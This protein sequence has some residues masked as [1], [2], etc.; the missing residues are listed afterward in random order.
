MYICTSK[1]F[2]QNFL[3]QKNIL[4][5]VFGH[6]CNY[7]TVILKLCN[8]FSDFFLFWIK[9]LG[10]YVIEKH[11]SCSP[12][13]TLQILF[14]QCQE[15]VDSHDLNKKHTCRDCS[16]FKSCDDCL[17]RYGCGWCGNIDN[18]MIGKCV[19]GDFYFG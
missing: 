2:I 10:V 19:D 11:S 15:W 7:K 1:D 9:S 16:I 18:R 17:S 5:K 14:G 6:T 3:L 12:T 8:F 13:K 4:D